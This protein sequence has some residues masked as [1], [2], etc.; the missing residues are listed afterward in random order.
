MVLAPEISQPF[1]VA[2]Y[3]ARPGDPNVPQGKA[4]AKLQL[5]DLGF[6]EHGEGG[7]EMTKLCVQSW[8]SSGV[9]HQSCARG[10]KTKVSANTLDA[11]L[12]RRWPGVSLAQQQWRPHSDAPHECADPGRSCL[13]CGACA[14]FSLA[15]TWTMPTVMRNCLHA[16]MHRRRSA[17]SHRSSFDHCSQTHASSAPLVLPNCRMLCQGGMACCWHAPTSA[18]RHWLAWRGASR[19]RS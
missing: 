10:K 14:A 15:A 17:C 5:H 12:L 7:R 18:L 9:A 8:C 13:S 6:I 3:E 11:R 16:L 1:D 19:R 2:L 4:F